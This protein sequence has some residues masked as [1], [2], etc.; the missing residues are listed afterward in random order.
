MTQRLAKTA[1]LASLPRL[2]V[3]RVLPATRRSART[4]SLS[5]VSRSYCIRPRASRRLDGWGC[6]SPS[7]SGDGASCGAWRG[8]VT[9]KVVTLFVTGASMAPR[10]ARTIW[11]AMKSPRPSPGG[12]LVRV[13]PGNASNRWGSQ[14]GRDG[15]T[16]RNRDAHGLGEGCHQRKCA[17]A[18]LRCH[19]AVRCRPGW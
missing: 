11:C 7:A 9:R 16:V 13:C 12:A 18:G 15:A 14:F 19:G 3:L 8:N 5:F 6:R 10:C 2:V 17:P 1:L 4:A